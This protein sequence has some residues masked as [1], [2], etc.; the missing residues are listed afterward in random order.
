MTHISACF[1]KTPLQGIHALG[2]GKVDECDLKLWFQVSTVGVHF[3]HNASSGLTFAVSLPKMQGRA[4][5]SKSPRGGS[6][7]CFF[8]DGGGLDTPIWGIISRCEEDAGKTCVC[9]VDIV[10]HSGVEAELKGERYQPVLEALQ[11]TDPESV[12]FR[13]EL[14]FVRWPEDPAP[15]YLKSTSGAT[16]DWSCIFEVEGSTA[17][18]V[19]SS[20]VSEDESSTGLA[21]EEIREGVGA[22]TS[23]LDRGYKTTFDPSQ[24]KAV[25]LAVNNRLAI[26]QGP[27]GT[28]KTFIGMKLLQLLLSAST[29]PLCL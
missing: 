8:D 17:L 6:L 27:P 26:I 2:K 11:L 13:E 16:L 3:N 28:G 18:E 23:L 15:E 9:F 21:E 19:E 24:L 20:S 25:E 5:D 12:P 10:V 29:F 7:V 4:K 1:R 14:V 22:M